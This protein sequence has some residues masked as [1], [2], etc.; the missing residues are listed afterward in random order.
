MKTNPYACDTVPAYMHWMPR[1]DRNVS[2]HPGG[3]YFW[4]EFWCAFTTPRGLEANPLWS[5][6][7]NKA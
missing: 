5:L 3:D 7:S 4:N 2:A 6:P 1:P